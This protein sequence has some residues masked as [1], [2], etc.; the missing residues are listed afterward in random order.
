MGWGEAAWPGRAA[1][2][3]LTPTL[4]MRNADLRC[5]NFRYFLSEARSPEFNVK[6]PKVYMLATDLI[7]FKTLLGPNTSHLW[8]RLGSWASGV[9]PP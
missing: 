5:H 9:C 7:I 6:S 3:L 2:A 4:V 8:A 1:A